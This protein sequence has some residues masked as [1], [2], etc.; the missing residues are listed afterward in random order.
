MF[1]GIKN[2]F[3]KVV[4]KILP[5]STIAESMKIKL[6]INDDMVKKIEDWKMLYKDEPEWSRTDL[7]DD[8]KTAGLASS[9]ASEFARLTT[10][11]FQSKV[12]GESERNRYLNENYQEVLKQIRIQTEYASALGGLMFKPFRDGDKISVDYVKADSFYPV[13]FDSRGNITSCIFP[14]YIQDGDKIYTRTEFHEFKDGVY[15]VTNNAFVKKGNST[16]K[17]LGDPIALTSVPEWAHLANYAELPNVNR[18]LFSYFKIP[19]ANTVNMESNLG[20]SVYARAEKLLKQADEHWNA[21]NWEFEAKEVALDVDEDILK[22]VRAG[23]LV[24]YSAIP[25]G[26]ER[27]FRTYEAETK[28]GTPFYNVYSPDIRNESYESGYNRIL[29]RIEFNCG[30]AYGTLSDPTIVSKTATEVIIAKQRSYATVNDIQNSLESALRDLVEVMDIWIDLENLAPRATEEITMTFD[31]DDSMITDADTESKIRL[32]E[33]SA[34]IVD[35]KHYIKWR[36]GVESDDEIMEI[37]PKPIEMIQ[38]T[39]IDETEE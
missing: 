25:K 33:V 26:K 11:E 2:I 37:M 32:S 5:A 36:Y 13:A 22:P 29:Q 27:M 10:L 30:L 24:S 38:G 7:W 28:T 21:M 4:S 9:I 18:P 39:E 16:T 17:D 34:G 3:Y 8:F 14:E 19:L 6:P 20:V 31:W 15:K 12:T 35:P 1:D 23:G